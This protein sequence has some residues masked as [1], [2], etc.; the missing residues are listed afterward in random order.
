MGWLRELM[1]AGPPSLNSYDALARR[2]LD[3]PA[4]DDRP[5]PRAR[6]LSALLG[7][8]D[9]GQELDWLAERPWMQEALATTLGCEVEVI[10][11]HARSAL[12]TH[13]QQRH[14]LRLADVPRARLLELREEE[15]CPG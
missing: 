9:R 13:D 6:S 3:S 5:L 15:P 8:L 1:R 2:V 11:R 14:H 10:A 7:K 4:L 12:Q